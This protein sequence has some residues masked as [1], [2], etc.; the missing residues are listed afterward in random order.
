MLL[1]ICTTCLTGIGNIALSTLIGPP[2]Q[3]TINWLMVKV[4]AHPYVRDLLKGV[5]EENPPLPKHVYIW[6]VDIVLRKMKDMP[7]SADLPLNTL[8]HKVPPLDTLSHKVATLLG[9]CAVQRGSEIHALNMKWMS[10][11]S[12]GYK[13]YFGFRVKH[14]DQ[15]KV[16][17]PVTFHPFPS[18]LKLCP[19]ANIDVYKARTSTLRPEGC[20]ILFVATKMPHKLV[21]K[22]TVAR[23]VMNMLS[24]AGIDVY[25]FQAHS[26]RAAASSKEA[27]TVSLSSKEILSMG[28]WKCESTWKKFYHKRVR[29]TAEKF[30]SALLNV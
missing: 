9:L 7:N 14:Q 5:A 13:C 22:C 20:Q 1:T 24:L 28:N 17:E 10:K 21:V 12:E 30:Q 25:Q 18:E 23:W 16:P 6:D 2:F 29:G 8:S 19:V 15:G 3:L 4:G 27:V 11:S 26:L